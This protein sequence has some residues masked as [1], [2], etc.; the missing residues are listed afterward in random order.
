[1]QAALISLNLTS[2]MHQG[3]L[4]LLLLLF[5]Q[6]LRFSLLFRHLC[7]QCRPDLCPAIQNCGNGRMLEL[8][9]CGC[10]ARCTK[11]VGEFCGGLQQLSCSPGQYCA[12]RPGRTFGYFRKGVCEPSEYTINV[13]VYMLDIPRPSIFTY[14]FG[15]WRH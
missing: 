13:T 8:D 11:L 9:E 14:V 10:C 7:S 2:K 5:V 15:Q 4:L 12:Y 1:M 6:Q 3:R